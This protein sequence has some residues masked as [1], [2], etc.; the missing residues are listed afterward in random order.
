[1]V[2]DL[3]RQIEIAESSLARQLAWIRAVE[4]KL[5]VLVTLSIAM[6]GLLANSIAKTDASI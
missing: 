5:A 3:E 4:S 2:I 6:L 1:M